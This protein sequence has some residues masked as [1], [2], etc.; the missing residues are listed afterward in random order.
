MR[1]HANLNKSELATRLG[2]S[3][4]AVSRLERQPLGASLRTL[5]KYANACGA[6]IALNLN[7]L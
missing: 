1:E 4:A 3:P 5:E 7:Y 2:V 6:Q